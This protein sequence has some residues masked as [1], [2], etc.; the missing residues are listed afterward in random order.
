[1]QSNESV[2]H[3]LLNLI[4]KWKYII[5]FMLANCKKLEKNTNSYAQKARQE[6]I[7]MFTLDA[8]G[9]SV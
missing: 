8:D 2:M 3:N 7:K 1:M 5:I 9:E 4:S 6:E